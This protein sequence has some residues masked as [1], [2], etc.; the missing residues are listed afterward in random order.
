MD[1][2]EAIATTTTLDTPK[3]LSPANPA[4][5]TGLDD[6]DGLLEASRA[7]GDERRRSK[8]VRNH[9]ALKALKHELAAAADVY[10]TTMV[11]T[12]HGD[13]DRKRIGKCR[14]VALAAMP[15]AAARQKEL[16]S[17]VLEKRLPGIGVRDDLR[18]LIT[19]SLHCRT[20]LDALGPTVD[21]RAAQAIGNKVLVELRQV[22]LMYLANAR[23]AG[24]GSTEQ[25][26]SAVVSYL[27]K[28]EAHAKGFEALAPESSGGSADTLGVSL[29]KDVVGVLHQTH[30][31][32]APNSDHS[33]G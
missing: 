7:I 16:A 26:R 1:D 19:L 2:H 24:D 30:L 14:K 18:Q 9:V 27:E 17:L 32:W 20:A 22:T 8:L 15:T 23:Q 3:A 11:A 33:A 21:K 10:A 29:S 5:E 25:P 28:A 4:L 31:S 6:L 13:L 12:L